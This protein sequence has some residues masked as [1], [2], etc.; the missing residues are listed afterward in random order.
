[1]LLTK[2]GYLFTLTKLYYICIHNV[3]YDA[4]TD[5]FRE[6]LGICMN[7]RCRNT[8]GSFLCECLPG[9]TQSSDRMNCR[10]EPNDFSIDTFENILE[11]ILIFLLALFSNN[12]TKSVI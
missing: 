9:Y 8:P 6:F 7:A 12:S 3:P 2:L 4:D 1:M 11:N 10:G 5:E